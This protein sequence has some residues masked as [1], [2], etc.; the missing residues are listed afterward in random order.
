LALGLRV[1]LEQETPIP[2]AA[3]FTC[4][5][6]EML[7]LVGPSGSGK[8]TILRCIAGLH[9]PRVGEVGCGQEVW[10]DTTRGRHLPPQRR[11]IGYVFQ[12]Y[13]L[14]PHQTALGNVLAAL[15][16]VPRA[17]RQRRGRELM[18]L[19]N[20]EGLESRRPAD[21][22]GGQQQ[23]VALA[24]ALARDPSVLLLDEPLSAVDQV[25]RRKLQRE[26]ARLRQRVNIPI[27]LVTHDLEEARMLADR[28]CILHRGETLQTGTPEDVM[29][30]PADARV[31]RMVNLSNVFHGTVVAQ[32]PGSM[33][34]LRWLDHTLA[35]RFQG[36]FE[37]GQSVD[38]VVPQQYVILHQR[39][40]PSRGD[41]ENPVT[42]VVEDFVL[43]GDIA[44]ITLLVEG[45]PD[46]SLSL[47][48]P[49]HVARRNRLQRGEQISVSLL[50][51]GLHLMM[52]RTESD[53]NAAT[54]Y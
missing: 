39:V 33:T 19:V 51:E 11:R 29:T 47:T 42:G 7:A 27:V 35:C 22:S 10:L 37:P 38:W 26:L 34:R 23:R 17:A 13:A 30:R 9:R 1:R 18:A 15:G 40:R 3:G 41:R 49:T 25:T 43:L 48:V 24:R 14:F 46:V 44:S 50:S 45:R 54:G 16:D 52:P 6:G 20:L 8:S 12:N 32:V 31:A 21:L 4:G 53:A 28:V 36:G 2:L 5:P